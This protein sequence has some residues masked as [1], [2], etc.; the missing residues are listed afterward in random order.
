MKKMYDEELTRKL[1]K[2][3]IREDYE[4]AKTMGEQ[5]QDNGWTPEQCNQ[6]G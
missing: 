3:K 5:I 2:K 4:S 6:E 1:E